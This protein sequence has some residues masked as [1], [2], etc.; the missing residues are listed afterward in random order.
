MGLLLTYGAGMRMGLGI[1]VV[2]L[3]ALTA[4]GGSESPDASKAPTPTAKPQLADTCPMVQMALDAAAGDDGM[5][6]R[7]EQ[8]DQFASEVEFFTDQV[9]PKVVPILEELGGRSRKVAP[10]LSSADGETRLGAA[11]DWLQSYKRFMD[12]CQS[13]GAPVRLPLED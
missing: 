4:C 12:A 10:L 7:T 6:L 3:V 1:A 13:V 9:D 2:A 5:L 8:Y 11:T